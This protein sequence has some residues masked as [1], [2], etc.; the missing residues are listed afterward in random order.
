MITYQQL[1]GFRIIIWNSVKL[2]VISWYQILNM[3]KFGLKLEMNA[4][5]S[6]K[7]KLLG[8]QIDRNLNFK[9]MSSLW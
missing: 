6:K 3:K 1:N 8:L 7:Q 2:K 9:Y 4:W 5:K